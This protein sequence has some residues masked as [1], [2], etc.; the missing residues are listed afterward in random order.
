MPLAL[1]PQGEEMKVVK[2]VGEQNTCRHLKDLGIT[3][4]AE[5]TLLSLSGGSMIVRVQ[6]SR[7]AIDKNVARSIIVCPKSAA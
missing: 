3:D 1:A 7:L 5:I 4:G 2:V 6:S